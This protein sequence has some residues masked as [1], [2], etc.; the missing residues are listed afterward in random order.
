LALAG[1]WLALSVA[2]CGAAKTVPVKGVVTFNDKPLAN[3]SVI[4]VTQEKGGRD[5]TGTTDANGAFQLSTFVP[6]DGALPGLYKVTVH[7]SEAVAPPPNLRT[8]EDVQKALVKAG[9]SKKP[10]V[11]IPPIY[12][13]PDRTV[14]KHRVP[15]DGDAKLE[16]KSGAR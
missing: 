8:A 15:E 2:G 10:A 9:A 16:L 11:I 6:K 4:F 5:A 12:S 1:A 3:A 13:Q 14:L 7:Y